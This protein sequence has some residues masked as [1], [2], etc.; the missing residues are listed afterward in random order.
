MSAAVATAVRKAV[1]SQWRVE[2]VN[3]AM[4]LIQVPGF[5]NV[6]RKMIIS[7]EAVAIVTVLKDPVPVSQDARMIGVT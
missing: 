3:G 4:R 5:V 2:N 6:D 1:I 7:Q